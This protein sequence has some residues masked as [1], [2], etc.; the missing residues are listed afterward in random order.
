MRVRA[1]HRTLLQ[2]G[3]GVSNVRVPR[4]RTRT[5]ESS[6]L[7]VPKARWTKLDRLDTSRNPRLPCGAVDD[8]QD[9]STR[10]EEAEALAGVRR[11]RFR[12]RGRQRQREL[13][14]HAQTQHHFGNLTLFEGESVVLA[15]LQS[16]QKAAGAFSTWCGEQSAATQSDTEIDDAL[17]TLMNEQYLGSG[18]AF[19][20]QFH[21]WRPKSSD[22]GH[23][24][25]HVRRLECGSHRA[26]SMWTGATSNLGVDVGGSVPSA[27]NKRLACIHSTRA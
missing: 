27:H 24:N 22:T 6:Y 16:Y 4:F 8:D 17:V 5:L 23:D 10:T 13:Q 11:E 3:N 19:S 26:L 15:T 18:N 25:C 2:T 21:A 9:D 12:R 20:L 14:R 1:L 7:V